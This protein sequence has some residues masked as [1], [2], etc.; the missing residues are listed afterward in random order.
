MTEQ[1]PTEAERKAAEEMR[2]RIQ[3]TQEIKNE[4]VMVQIKKVKHELVILEAR[5]LEAN[6]AAYG[7]DKNAADLQAFV[8][9]H[10]C[11][12]VDVMR[13]GTEHQTHTTQHI[14]ETAIANIDKSLTDLTNPP[15]PDGQSSIR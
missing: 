11:A 14:A 7:P 8:S 5:C 1:Q 15:A 13:F 3:Q 9:M 4:L 2:M 10:S 12:L 6:S